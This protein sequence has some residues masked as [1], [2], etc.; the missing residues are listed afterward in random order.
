MKIKN[1]MTLSR[2]GV[3]DWFWQRISAIY[4]FSY[5]IFLTLYTCWH[6]VQFES[7]HELFRGFFMQMATLLALL[8]LIAHAWI[9]MWTIGTD[10]IKPALARMVYDLVILAAL[11]FFLVWGIVILWG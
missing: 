5:V 8:S 7:W 6:P 1:I 11:I 4:L 3:S 9:G 10:Y 2:S